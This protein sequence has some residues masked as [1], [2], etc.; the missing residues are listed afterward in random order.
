MQKRFKLKLIAAL[1]A[2]A[3]VGAAWASGFQLLE[4]NGSGIATAYAGSAAIADNASTIFFNPAGMTK[5]QA[6]EF[7]VGLDAVRPSFKFSNNGTIITPA[8]GTGT[9]DAG[10]WSY[11]PNGYLSWALNKDVY[12]GIG[13]SAPFGL[14]TD[15]DPTWVGR[16]QSISFDIKTYNINPSIAW[17]VNDKVSLGFGVNWQR[18]E[19]EYQRYAAVINS[20][21]QNTKV[22]LDADDD[23][24]GW[25]AGVLFDLSPATRIGISYRS[26]IKHT[27]EGTLKFSGPAAQ[28]NALM[29]D[30]NA[31]G[32]IKLPDTLILSVVQKLDDRWTMLGDLSWTGW[33]SVNKVD[34]IRTSG[35]LNGS[36][37]Q[38]LDTD[39]R[40]TWR[41]AFGG[42]YQYSADWDLRFGIA[43]DQTPVKNA[44][45]RLTSLPDNDR[46]WL[47]FGGQ[48]KFGKDAKLDLGAAYLYVKDTAIDNNQTLSGRG[49]VKGSYDSSVWILG[50]QYSQAF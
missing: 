44:Q 33:S 2:A 30:V 36:T 41:V 17:K 35:V 26:A 16:F 31:K 40:D 4:Q 21:T 6:R 46:L 10:D 9:G 8:T 14:K 24:W 23:S 25:N 50:A 5:L 42:I 19:A 12:L 28:S 22:V 43:Y 1:V 49:W 18:M 27:L 15:Y 48:R 45:K 32:E 3:P 38:T 7:S 39:F 13:L 37:A 11:I 47:S 29:T 20:A 34:I